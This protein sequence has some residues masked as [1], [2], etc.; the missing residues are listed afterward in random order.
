V[1][2]ALSGGLMARLVVRG[3]ES[4]EQADVA[5]GVVEELGCRGALGLRGVAVGW[6]TP[7]PTS[8]SRPYVPSDPR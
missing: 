5:R 2:S 7:T 1:A 8:S 6:R 4:K 3:F